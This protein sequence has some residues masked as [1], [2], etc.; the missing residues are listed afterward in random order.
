MA[1]TLAFTSAPRAAAQKYPERR[2]VRSGN[3]KYDKGDFTESEV[4]YRR[5]LELNPELEQAKFNLADALF[6]QENYAEAEQL[7]GEVA[8]IQIAQGRREDAARSRFN[9]ANAMAAQDKIKEAVEEYKESL[10]LNP[11]DT[12]AKFNYAFLK[13]KLEEQQQEQEQNQDQNKDQQDKQEQDKQEQNQDQQNQQDQQEQ[14]DQQKQPEQDDT[15]E[16]PA[17]MNRQEAEQMLEAIQM[18]EDKTR[19]KV[20]EGK[21][22]QA[23]GA[24]G[25][26]W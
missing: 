5:A 14:Q 3:D 15:S 9:A 11:G 17:G 18:S 19:E 22:V 8:K 20:E 1:A 6:K 13:K 21:R 7:F 12:E 10:R 24:S 23:V 16:Q 25:K 2:I 4:D 26:N